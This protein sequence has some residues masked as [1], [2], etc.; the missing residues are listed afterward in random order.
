MV[1]A[2]GLD[3][4]LER[5]GIPC[6]LLPA[7]RSAR[8]ARKTRILKLALDVAAMLR[9]LQYC[10]LQGVFIGDSSLLLVKLV[11]EVAMRRP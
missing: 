6:D 2:S 8:D 9:R 1:P 7:L 10:R 4:E 3:S 5:I 11:A